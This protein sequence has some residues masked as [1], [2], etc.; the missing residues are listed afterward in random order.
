LFLY[1][2]SNL[3]L[4]Y[5]IFFNFLLSSLLLVYIFSSST[6]VMSDLLLTYGSGSA[7]ILGLMIGGGGFGIFNGF[8]PGTIGL[9]C[10]G[11][12]SFFGGAGG[13]ILTGNYTF[14]T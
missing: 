7:T 11:F 5:L 10:P 12:G 14:S 3:L 4:N 6:G 9:P 1:W 13:A 2:G 8:L